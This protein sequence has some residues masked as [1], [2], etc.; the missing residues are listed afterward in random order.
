MATVRLTVE[1]S[2]EEALAYA[3]FLKRIGY[4][5]YRSSASSE[6]EAYLMRDAGYSIRKALAEEGFD[7]R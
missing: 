1:L 4:S 5:D 3:Q 7:P 6:S 2:E